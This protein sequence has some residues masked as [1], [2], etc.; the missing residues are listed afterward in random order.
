MGANNCELRQKARAGCRG[1]APGLIAAA[2][3]TR[4]AEE[5]FCLRGGEREGGDEGAPH[6][7]GN[8]TISDCILRMARFHMPLFWT[9]ASFGADK[10]EGV[11]LACVSP[12]F[13]MPPL[14]PPPLYAL[15]ILPKN[16]Y[17][18]PLFVY[19]VAAVTACESVGFE[20]ETSHVLFLEVDFFFV[21]S[22]G[23]VLV[24]W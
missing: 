4:H 2:A 6:C 1:R 15:L 7:H 21:Q 10:S 19:V 5:G 12:C 13:L 16:R 3:T 23:L 22:R 14:H 11:M 20:M 17:D 24:S 9:D 18:V 8:L